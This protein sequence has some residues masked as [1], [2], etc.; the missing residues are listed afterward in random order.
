M[1]GGD[2]GE[3]RD[4]GT[5][6]RELAGILG[7]HTRVEV[8]LALAP[9]PTVGLEIVDD[10]PTVRTRAEEDHTVEL[11]RRPFAVLQHLERAF[12][13]ELDRI[14]RTHKGLAPGTRKNRRFAF[15]LR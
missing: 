6:S 8:R 5:I 7:G 10:R 1:V 15:T 12:A 13:P 4:R 9:L 3:R 2:A 11:T 14:F